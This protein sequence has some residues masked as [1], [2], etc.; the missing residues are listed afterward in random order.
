MPIKQGFVLTTISFMKVIFLQDVKGVGKTDE[1]KEVAEGYARNFL[2]PKHLAVQASTQAVQELKAHQAKKAKEESR[3]LQEQQ[4]LAEKLDG[5]ALEFKEKVSEKGLLYAAV[6]SASVVAEL[7]K[8]NFDID[9]GQVIL[10]PIKEVGEY[11]AKVKLRH[12]LE[13]SVTITVFA[14]A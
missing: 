6:T 12:G 7:K 5:L 1:V 2:F 13:A 11:Q 4:Q 14:R 3:D 10:S 8:K 9:K